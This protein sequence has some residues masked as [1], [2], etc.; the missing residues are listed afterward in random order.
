QDSHVKRLWRTRREP[1]QRHGLKKILLMK[2]KMNNGEW[3]MTRAG[4]ILHSPFSILHFL[5]FIA[6][7]IPFGQLAYRAYTGDLG[8]NPI[9]TITRF[10]GSWG[11]VFF[12]GLRAGTRVGER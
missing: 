9:E 1:V 6:C 12:L 11:P 8:V 3:K 10:T 4:R 2:W 5:L 7:L